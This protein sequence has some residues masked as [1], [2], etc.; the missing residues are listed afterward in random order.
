MLEK[1]FEPQ[2]AEPR[3]YAQWEESGLF[4]PRTDGTAEAYSIVIPPP[5]VTGSL[6]IGHALNNTLQDI[7]ARYHRMRGKAVLWLPGTDHAGIAT[8]MV[9]ERQLAAVGNVGRRDM[10]RDAFIEKVWEWKAESG[11]T[12]VRQLRRLGAS[13]D[14]SRERF[15]LDEGLN[16]A[17]RKV[18]VQLHKEGLI[19]RDKR[20]VNW[21][22]HF[23]TAISDLE[24]EQREVD[25]A[26]WHFAYPLADGVTYEHPV[27]FDEDGKATE[28]ETRD[29]IVV[30]TTRP[31]TMLGDTGVAVHPEDERYASLVGKFVTLPITGRRIP[32]V[33][34]DYA[35]PTKGSGAVKITP[36]HDFNDFGVGKR[37]GLDVINVMDQ[38]ARIR[39][40]ND[41]SQENRQELARS[42]SDFTYLSVNMVEI[43]ALEA[44]PAELRGLDRFAARKAIVARAEA[45]GWLRQIEKTKHVVPHGDRSGVVIEP[46]LTDQWYVDAKVLA[47]PALKAVE[48]GD[49]VFEPKSYEKIYFEWLRNI[50]PWCISRQLWWG[51]RIPAWYGP[52][53]EIYVAETEEDAREQAM[54]DYDSEVA[55]T[56]DEDVLDTWF[57]S[58]LWPF[59]TMGWPEKTEDL[60]RFYPTSDLV[61]AADIIFFWVARM[62]MMGLHFMDEVPFKRVIINGLV[63]DEKGQKMSKSKGNVIDP[64]GIID[65]LGADPLRFTMAI[66]S[67]TRDI[68]LSKQRIEGYRNFGTKLWNAARFSQMNEARRVEGFDP[69][70]VEQ[71]INRWIRGELTKAERAVSDAIE[72]GR[73]DDAAGALYRFVWNVFC[74][75]YLELAKP[76]FN[77]A[78][79]AAKAETRAMTAWTLDQTLKLLHPVMPFIT[80]ELWAELG[81]EG[82]AREGL[83]IGAE[84]PVL[85]DA[86]ID[87]SAEAEIGWLVDLVGEIRGLR[88]EMNVPPSAKPPLAFVAPDAGTAERIARHRD[89]ILTLGRV[90]EVGSAD[91]APTGAVTFVSGGS[92]V[93]L[94]LAGI[95]DL[96]AERARL[97]KEIAA[98]DSDIGHVNKKLGN[99]NFVA[100][101]APEVVDEQRAKLAE[102]EAGKVKLQAA[103]ARLS[104]IG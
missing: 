99:P 44:I 62:M 12:I 35:D 23:Q 45:E 70:T 18:F 82:P 20:L 26:Y 58:A 16:A 71:T 54:A 9:V 4:A 52:N 69:A 37:A 8:Q 64:L 3:L 102:A 76:V 94:S 100:R 55:L 40:P 104:E 95:I 28:W 63:R 74:D 93:A 30:A 68:K 43:D 98:F 10:G 14:W 60:E 73:F 75:W 13:C 33:A 1:T 7:L 17:V 21:D 32:I 31:E 92:T 25:G 96:T 38:F 39:Q 103:L 46:W 81:K 77:G 88:A 6:H 79:E 56:Q 15:T 85:P 51:H 24:V 5:N 19:Y 50:E 89:L 66:L 49:T 80:E 59:S 90:S 57:S 97:E 2:A 86:F 83:L 42:Q 61:T 101:A 48:Q 72:G 41:L 34:D 65:E 67:G 87:A 29:F 78:D 22:P 36:A 53:G 91:A 47:Q 27:G 84:W 11:G